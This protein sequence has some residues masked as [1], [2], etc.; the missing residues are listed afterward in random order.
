MPVNTTIKI[1]KGTESEWQSSNPILAS[2]EPGY[3]TNTNRFKIGDG[4]TNWNSLSYAAV[5]PSGF[6]AGSGINIV[7]GSQGISATISVSGL[8][9]SYLSDFNEAVD[10]RIG[11][12]LFVAGTGID[13]SYNDGSN[14]FTVSV[15]GLINNPTDNRILTSRDSS[16]TGI[17]AESNLTFDGSLLTVSGNL[18]ANTGTLDILQFN[19][20]NGLVSAQGQMG[21]NSTQGTVDVALTSTAII[22]LGEHQMYRI[23]NTISNTLYRG[24]PV[25]ASGVHANG[26][27]TPNLYISD[28]SID[29]I[30]FIGL[31]YETVNN[32]NNGYVI[33]FGHMYNI[34]T[35][36]NVASDIAVGDETWADG[37]ILYPHPTVTGKLTKV[38]PKHYIPIAL[39]LDA[40]SNGK[41]YVRRDLGAGELDDLH[42]VN[43]SGVT[44]GQ[45][46]QYNS[47][48]DYWVASSS[49]NFTTLQLN[50]TTVSVS[51]HTHTSSDITNFDSSVSGLLPTISN[52]GDNRILTSTGSTGGITAESNLTFDGSLLNI[53][54]S[55]SFSSNLRLNGQTANTI[56]GFDSSKNISSL[57]TST[58]PNLTELSYIKDVTSAIQTQLNNKAALVHTHVVNDITN[59]AS[60]V[61]DEISTT[62]TAGTGI[63]LNYDSGTDSLTVS[64]TGLI[65]NPANSR[66]LTSRDNTT[67]GID[68]ESNLTFDGTT[69]ICSGNARIGDYQ[70]ID[71]DGGLI[72]VK[73]SDNSTIMSFEEYS[74]WDSSQQ[75]SIYWDGKQL[76][77][78]SDVVLD[79]SN[80]KV[81]IK[82]VTPVYTLDVNGSGNFASGLA[83]SN[84]TASTIAGFDS[85]KNVTS[86]S[87][88]TYPSLTELSYVKGVTS[89]IQT[90]LNAKQNI[91]TN[92]VT[93]T[94]AANH[95]AYWT[96][97]S[98]LGHD[99]SQ[100]YWDAT[101]NRLGIGTNSPQQ[102][103]HI[104]GATT[105]LAGIRFDN[106]SGQGGTITAANNMLYFNSA[107]RVSSSKI[108][109]GDGASTGAIEL[110][111]NGSISQD[112]NG[113]GLTFSGTTG[114]FS[115]SLEI[116]G[117]L[118]VNTTGVVLGSG[119][120]NYAPRWLSS[121][122]LSTGLIFDNGS[123]VMIGGNSTSFRLDVSSTSNN[124]MQ[125]SVGGHTGFDIKR[126]TNGYS[127]L[128]VKDVGGRKIAVTSHPN[129]LSSTIPYIAGIAQGIGNGVTLSTANVSDHHISLRSRGDFVF[130]DMNTNS[131]IVN[132]KSGGN[133]GIGII[134]PSTKL[135]VAGSIKSS[136][137]TVWQ[138]QNNISALDIKSSG[139]TYTHKIYA[140]SVG[141]AL[142]IASPHSIQY[143]G[144]ASGGSHQFILGSE[145]WRMTKDTL[146]PG[147]ASAA[148][149]GGIY[150]PIDGF[151]GFGTIGSTSLYKTFAINNRVGN[152]YGVKL[153]YTTGG[154]LTDGLVLN[155]TGKVGIGTSSPTSSL[156][157]SGIIQLTD[158]AGNRVQFFR[159]GGTQYDYSIAKEGNH[160]AISTANDGSTFRYTQFGY[161]SGSTWTPKT[162]INNYNGNIGIGT[163]SPTVA[164][165]AIGSGIFT[166]GVQVGD[167]S[168]NAYLIGPS[169]NTY[170]RFNN[171]AFNWIE[172]ASNT[173]SGSSTYLSTQYS[174]LN[175]AATYVN[176]TF[177]F[178]KAGNV[179]TSTA[180][181]RDSNSILM[182]NRLWN[183]SAESAPG[184]E[185]LSKAS[186]SVNLRSRFSFLMQNE[187]GT[188]N[189]TERF[190]I[191]SNGYIGVG[192]TDPSYSLDVV[193]TGN[194][195]Q[196][197]LVNGTG[198]SISGHTHVVNDITDFSTGVADE[199]NTT[200]TAGSGIVL[201]YDSG[202]DTLTIHT[203]GVRSKTLTYF[204]PLDNQPPAS[205]FATLD[206]RNSIAI[207]DFDDTTEESAVFVGVI[208]ENAALGS[209]ISVRIHWMAT[210]ATSGNC[211]WGVQFEKMTSDL[212]SDSFDTATEA[213]SA[214]NGTAGVVTITTI[215]CTSIDSLAAGDLFRIKVYRDVSD[216]T[217]DTMVG[218]AE[219]V[220]IE[221]R[222]VV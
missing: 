209:G 113:G 164:L 134:S 73:N 213:H 203:S 220:A 85:N 62:I 176:G 10:D 69:F 30:R 149:S 77:N 175:S 38:P 22:E 186:T 204:T 214:T 72:Y 188:A 161:H 182:Y 119:T 181:Q 141:Y 35:R 115:N 172:L 178:P 3:V 76:V 106:S 170:I 40:A 167:S 193:G 48:T 11:S 83:I 8:S 47:S 4:S 42:D 122:I 74:L 132:I 152:D 140:N 88:S 41:L 7:L 101:N 118:T 39:I 24:Q 130:I 150:A 160:L 180:T 198:V 59:F 126:S 67:T 5:V 151:L 110:T 19:T 195:S 222:S 117:N 219:I 218:D 138:S 55:G 165:H 128:I 17:D 98:G 185:I 104:S 190:S 23:R 200:L 13:L 158:T 135:D 102:L 93:G 146:A 157:V 58:Y 210:S 174:Y 80:N 143:S 207:L 196:N 60:G 50:G 14:S 192:N 70:Y 163:S 32:N 215:T 144:G 116:T 201:D 9:T 111:S 29:E 86:L 114:R 20:N 82:N 18:V 46:L 37:D 168:S 52:S 92:P 78:G 179:P 191:L 189:R 184:N 43:V 137:I 79:W 89:A 125:A 65:S 194:F 68:A 187:D 27:I 208:P 112:G 211:R 129:D 212:D 123:S 142:T 15:T 75:L 217:N 54:G 6:L 1:R 81:G 34:D 95:I 12:G 136:G 64:V 103:I 183:G 21:W 87:T 127:E 199:V 31:M 131:Q 133:V 84:Q 169:G 156:T 53:T 36:G 28:G 66:I 90:Q 166:S 44:D 105:A 153:L 124:I 33:A 139:G 94:G 155:N 45:F 205:A 107:F 99:A 26:L 71:V 171:G 177:Q 120:I 100:L 221:L 109:L 91:L 197:L 49:G 154:N 121:S 147:V 216:T 63:N 25:Y 51:G 145:A 202:T 162:V 148:A 61:A 16:T 206:T 159:G 97:A 2:G 108:R 173:Y 96:S 57:S 56:A